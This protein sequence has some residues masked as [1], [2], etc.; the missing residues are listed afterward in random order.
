[1]KTYV[2]AY[3]L[4][5]FGISALSVTLMLAPGVRAQETI[6]DLRRK[7]TDSQKQLQTIEQEIREQRLAARPRQAV[8]GRFVVVDTEFTKVA[9]AEARVR[10]ATQNIH[11]NRSRSMLSI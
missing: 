10:S 8:N 5:L 2:R 4:I 7:I 6:D 9:N 3:S 11:R 1:M